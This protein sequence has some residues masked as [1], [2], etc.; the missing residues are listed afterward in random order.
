MQ[1]GSKFS[2]RGFSILELLVVVAIISL[3][4]AALVALVGKLRE[5]TRMGEAKNLIE[6]LQN[7]L[8]TYHLHFRGFPASNAAGYTQSEV[9]RYH[10]GSA[11]KRGANT[12]KGE[13]E[14]SINVGP[15]IA[16]QPKELRDVGGRTIIVDPWG[17]EIHYTLEMKKDGLNFDIP[18]PLLYSFGTN[19]IDDG[20]TGDDLVVGK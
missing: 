6:K 10:L 16:F 9:L 18:T 5:R 8:E 15:L 1:R 13:V 12:A 20:G 11:F 2:G 17:K 19:G 4:M 14:A 7:G 3:L